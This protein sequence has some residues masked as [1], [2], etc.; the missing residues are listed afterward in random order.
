V[1][2]ETKA[3]EP[4]H[5]EDQARSTAK[6]LYVQ[7]EAV[8]T[9]LLI[10]CRVI[11][12]RE[13]FLPGHGLTSPAVKMMIISK[14]GVGRLLELCTTDILDVLLLPGIARE[15]RIAH[16]HAASTV[17]LQ[18]RQEDDLE[19]AENEFDFG[20]FRV[21]L[22]PEQRQA[23]NAISIVLQDVANYRSSIMGGSGVPPLFRSNRYALR[24]IRNRW[25]FACSAPLS[26]S[27]TFCIVR[28]LMS[29]QRYFEPF[30]LEQWALILQE[31]TDLRVHLGVPSDQP[32]P[33]PR[34]SVK[35]TGNVQSAIMTDANKHC[36]VSAVLQW[37]ITA[38][39]ILAKLKHV[40]WVNLFGFQFVDNQEMEIETFIALL[41]WVVRIIAPRAAVLVLPDG[42]E[43]MN[44]AEFLEREVRFS[45]ILSV[46]VC[47]IDGASWRFHLLCAWCLSR[48]KR[49]GST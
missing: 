31:M 17:T 23:V 38:Q 7:L 43:G 40:A 2:A 45:S 11:G 37:G 36:D 46:I 48:R 6:Q 21:R 9:T 44:V 35:R 25:V 4:A 34:A 16:A 33:A 26:S 27:V 18:K 39:L 19:G 5:I 1:Q 8:F 10:L 28:I 22:D 20:G 42:C 15:E 13:A 32:L 30:V 41:S 47:W 14:L 49:C 3:D 12:F 29:R 24:D